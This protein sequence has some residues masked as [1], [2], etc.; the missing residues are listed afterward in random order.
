MSPCLKMAADFNLLGPKN[1][2]DFGVH[3]L[4]RVISFNDV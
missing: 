4:R 3:F 2:L 1:G